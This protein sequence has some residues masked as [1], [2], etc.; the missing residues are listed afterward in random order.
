MYGVRSLENDRYPERIRPRSLSTAARGEGVLFRAVRDTAGGGCRRRDWPLSSAKRPQ[1]ISGGSR[2]CGEEFPDVHFVLCGDGTTAENATL[3]AQAQEAGV[4][5]R[6]HWL[7][8]REPD[9]LARIMSRCILVSSSLFGEGFSNV[10]GEAMACGAVC[11]VTDVGDSAWIVGNT[12]VVVR[13]GSAEELAGAIGRVLSISAES[14]A[15]M[16]AAARQRIASEFT[17]E[18]IVRRYE[19]LYTQVHCG[20]ADGWQAKPLR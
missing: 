18:R 7:G 4:V 16:G 8:R 6:M 2:D 3:V 19:D 13:R 10:V 11:V 12:G 5:S 9:E 17:I 14:R 15:S 1:V 20:E